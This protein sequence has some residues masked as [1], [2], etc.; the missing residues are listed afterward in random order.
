LTR[1]ACPTP[2]DSIDLPI[3]EDPEAK[4]TGVS[5]TGAFRASLQGGAL[6]VGA[7]D[8]VAAGGESMP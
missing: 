6:T 8:A 1:R 4:T 2:V 5:K 7:A 3:G